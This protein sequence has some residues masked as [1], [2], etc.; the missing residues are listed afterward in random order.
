M[1]TCTIRRYRRTAGHD[2][3]R[4]GRHDDAA[5]ND[6]VAAIQIQRRAFNREI[7]RQV[8][9]RRGQQRTVQHHHIV[10][11]SILAVDATE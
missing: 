8:Y 7:T 9:A 11:R 1:T 10:A 4:T 2:E 5:I 6:K 3:T